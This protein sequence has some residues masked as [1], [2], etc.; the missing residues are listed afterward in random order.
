MYWGSTPAKHF[1]STERTTEV[2]FGIK[3]KLGTTEQRRNGIGLRC[4]GDK[5]YA[6]VECSPG[7]FKEEGLVPGACIAEPR[8]EFKARTAAQAA[9]APGLADLSAYKRYELKTRRK[10]LLAEQEAVAHLGGPADDASSDEDD[11][12]APNGEAAAQPR[13]SPRQSPR[14]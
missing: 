12:A 2:E 7:Y 6:A 4:P 10:L 5:S 14:S 13:A 3:R 1:V 11:Q 8:K 9:E